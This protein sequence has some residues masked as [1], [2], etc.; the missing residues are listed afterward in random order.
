MRKRGSVL[1]MILWLV[2]ILAIFG[3]GLAKLSWSA[4]NFAKWRQNNFFGLYTVNSV[5]LTSK[6]ERKNDITPNYDSLLELAHEEE[7]KTGDI[8]V[9]YSLIDEE[10]KINVNKVSSSVLKNLPGMDIDIAVKVINSEY[11]PFVPKEKLLFVEEISKSVFDQIKDW[12]TVYGQ[13]TVNINTCAEETL[14]F[15]GVE[16]AMIETIMTFRL[17]ED[18][19]LYTEDDG[20]FEFSGEILNKL[21]E[22]FNLTLREEQDLISLISKNIIG[23]NSEI[24]RLEAKVYAQ[25]KL[26]SEYSI[27]FGRVKKQGEFCIKEWSG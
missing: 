7:Y 4:Y 21:K 5:F 27:V 15:L 19:V 8:K 13:G 1:V 9:V 14:S 22:K 2:S 3:M 10:R 26:I 24:Y 23:V 17:G 12:I 25:K 6:F 20:V 11:R 16:K 18:N